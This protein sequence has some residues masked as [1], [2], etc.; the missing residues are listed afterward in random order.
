MLKV[1]R[2]PVVM[3]LVDSTRMK[4]APSFTPIITPAQAGDLPSIAAL[5]GAV[6]RHH[7]PGIISS[8]QIEYMLAR[9]YSLETMRQEISSG[10]IRYDRLLHAGEM[11]GFSAFGPTSTAGE[12][13]LHKLYVHPAAQ[14]RGFGSV[15]LEHVQREVRAA[16]GHALVLAVNKANEKAIAAYRKNGFRIRDAVVMDIGGGFVMDDYVME[17]RLD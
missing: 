6:W 7:Y 14:R 11:A 8:E 1:R 16:R 5:A 15:L 10:G 4:I 12:F 9:M 2:S 13:K 17:K 3:G